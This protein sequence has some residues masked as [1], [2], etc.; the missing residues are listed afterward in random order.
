[1]TT[2]RAPAL[3]LACL[4]ALT[5]TASSAEEGDLASVEVVDGW[6]TP[7]G[8]RMAGLRIRVAPGWKTYWR[9]PGET[10]VPPQFDWSGSDN[11]Q[12][13]RIF[14]PRPEIFD[15]GDH[16]TL[17]YSGEVVLPVELIPQD[18][19]RPVRVAGR[20]ELGLCRDICVA[21]S[22]GYI[23]EGA[24]AAPEI[25]AAMARQPQ[26]DGLGEVRC[27]M[28]PIADG[29]RLTASM[30]APAQG[31]DE[32]AVVELPGG[33]I[34]VSQPELRREGGRVIATA[35]LVPPE[36]RPFAV[37]R[38]QLRITLLGRDGAREAQ[39]CLGG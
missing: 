6:Q 2:F 10:G 25:R 7:E 24:A 18:A 23:V 37:D 15:F 13:V 17:G 26:P 35:D 5:A 33:D 11:L 9:A 27:Q 20:A 19:S 21:V 32:M 39:G 1:M 3:I 30:S 36:A 28:E 14:W 34:W 31:G 16:R 8:S 4:A 29:M 38:S 22:K 12:A